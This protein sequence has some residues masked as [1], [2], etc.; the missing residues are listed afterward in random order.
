MRLLPA[1]LNTVTAATEIRVGKQRGCYALP[2][3]PHLKTMQRDGR[4]V[5][6]CGSCETLESATRRG[7]IP[8]PA[9][10][11]EAMPTNTSASKQLWQGRCTAIIIS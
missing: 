10:G 7:S 8:D 11:V 9:G 5:V 1:V 2:G 3:Q 6:T 4:R